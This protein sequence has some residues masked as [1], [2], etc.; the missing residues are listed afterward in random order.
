M[1]FLFFNDSFITRNYINSVIDLQDRSFDW[2]AV[3]TMAAKIAG[4]RRWLKLH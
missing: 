2:Q 4:R 3:F 1:R